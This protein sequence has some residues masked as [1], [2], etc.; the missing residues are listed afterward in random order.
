VTHVKYRDTSN[1]LQTLSSSLYLVRTNTLVGN[2]E[3]LTG[4][5][6][7]TYTHPRAVEIQFVAGYTV[8]TKLLQ[9]AVLF[10]VAHYAKIKEPTTAENRVTLLSKSQQHALDQLISSLRVPVS[11]ES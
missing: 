3:L 10:M 8:P 1:V 4:S 2:V 7:A 11:Y 9:R 6:P 5:W